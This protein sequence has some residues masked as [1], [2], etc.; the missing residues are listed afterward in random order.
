MFRTNF[1]S[2]VYN[3]EFLKNYQIVCYSVTQVFFS[4]KKLIAQK[5]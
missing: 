4:W 2:L 5:F 3:T 1:D